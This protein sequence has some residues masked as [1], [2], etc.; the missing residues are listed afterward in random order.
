LAR[1]REPADQLLG[2]LVALPFLMSWLAVVGLWKI[3][4]KLLSLLSRITRLPGFWPLVG[5]AL[6][7]TISFF[8]LNWLGV[9][10]WLVVTIAISIAMAT[11]FPNQVLT[12]AWRIRTLAEGLRPTNAEPDEVERRTK[13]PTSGPSQTPAPRVELSPREAEKLVKEWMIALGYPDAKTTQYSQDGGVD[14]LT[15]DYAVQVKR[16]RKGNNLGVKDVRELFGVATKLGKKPLFF[17][18]SGASSLALVEA[19]DMG[20]AIIRFDF[21]QPQLHPI[22]EVAKEFLKNSKLR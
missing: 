7:P 11:F 20:V 4:F 9:T 19:N 22:N 14:V 13:P 17:I 3:T 6:V 8:A 15:E 18:T 16:W 10:D 21:L 5:K 1:R 12:L 2:W